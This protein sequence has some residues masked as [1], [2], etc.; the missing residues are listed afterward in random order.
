MLTRLSS[1]QKNPC[2][3]PFPQ[4][5][6]QWQLFAISNSSTKLHH[7]L[8]F[9]VP[10]RERTN[11][12]YISRVIVMESNHFSKP[13]EMLEWPWRLRVPSGVLY[14]SVLGVQ[15]ETYT[16]TKGSFGLKQKRDFSKAILIDVTSLCPNCFISASVTYRASK[17]SHCSGRGRDVID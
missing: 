13:I 17:S 11:L 1:F 16:K 10:R 5:L 6:S 4:P 2:K 3:L 14:Q 12:R 15:F 8:H 9:F 7:F